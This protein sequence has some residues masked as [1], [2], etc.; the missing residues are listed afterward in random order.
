MK[1]RIV[2]TDDK[3]ILEFGVCG[4]KSLKRPG[5]PE[6]LKWLKRRFQEGLKIKALVSEKDGMQGMIEYL[7]GDLC[8]W[9]V[10]AKG[11]T[12]IHCLFSGFRRPYK[13]KGYGSMLLEACLMDA[14]KEKSFGVAV[15]TR[16]G[17]FMVGDGLFM[18]H[19]FEV[20]DTAPSDFSLLVK[21]FKKRT[22]P[23]RFKPGREARLKK[24]KKGLTIL[25]ADQCPY[26][27][28]NVEEICETARKEYRLKPKVIHLKNHKEA[29]NSPCAFGTFCMIFEGEVISEHP[30]SNRRFMN[31]M[32]KRAQR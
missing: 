28:K 24:Y 17:S 22:P 18:K 1:V 4:Y 19:G 15:V 13:N 10:E 11:Y 9:P 7:P 14:R 3:N 31:I 25:R 23:P 20:V 6:K 21:R 26:T 29:Q 8:W 5:F 16:K 27:V 32:N 2:D 12:F 30:I